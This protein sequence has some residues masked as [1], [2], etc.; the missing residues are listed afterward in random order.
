MKLLIKTVMR[1]IQNDSKTT[2]LL[3]LFKCISTEVDLFLF[4]LNNNST[5]ICL[6]DK[7]S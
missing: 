1:H 7:I 6:A 5:N 2:D 3:V 4:N